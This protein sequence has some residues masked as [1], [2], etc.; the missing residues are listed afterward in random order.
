M[1][2]VEDKIEEYRSWLLNAQGLSKFAVPVYVSVARQLEAMREE[3]GKEVIDRDVVLTYLSLSRDRTDE[4]KQ[5][6]RALVKKYLRYLGLDELADEIK[7]TK[8]TKEL[9]WWWTV[10]EVKKIFEACRDDKELIIVSFGYLQAMRRS[11]IAN[12]MV[13]DID[14]DNALIRVRIAKKRGSTVFVV[15]ELYRGGDWYPDQVELLRRYIERNGLK[16]GM[17]LLPYTPV[18]L[19]MIF[20]NIVKR[21]GVRTSGGSGRVVKQPGIHML[22]HSRCAHLRMA[23][24]PLDVISRWLGHASI[25][26]TM[27]YAHISPPELLKMVPPPT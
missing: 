19:N 22:R 7:I 16:P 8:T 27:L 14:L 18:Y 5:T 9:E 12:V 6:R 2:T 20:R 4:S 25:S 26:T 11:E 13:D 17:R 3:M 24:V 1:G 15:K 21:A 23:G 10:D